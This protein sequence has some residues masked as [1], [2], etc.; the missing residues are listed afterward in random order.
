MWDKSVRCSFNKSIKEQTRIVEK[1]MDEQ[2]NLKA[3]TSKE[4]EAGIARERKKIIGG[5]EL[6]KGVLPKKYCM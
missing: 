6:R 5:H 4:I 1:S 2:E 3:G